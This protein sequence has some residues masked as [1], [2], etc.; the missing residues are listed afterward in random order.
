LASDRAGQQRAG[1]VRGLTVME[2]SYADAMATLKT[3]LIALFLLVKEFLPETVCNDHGHIVGLCSTRALM[4]PPDIFNYAASMRRPGAVR[5]PG[6]GVA[7][8]EQRA[9]RQDD[10]L[11]LQLHPHAHGPRGPVATA[12]SSAHPPR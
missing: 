11:R 1:L 10:E 6:H 12:I 2:G 9:A 5:G 7:L 8:P 4:L 3:K